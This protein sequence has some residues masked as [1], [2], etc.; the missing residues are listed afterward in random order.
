MRF[1]VAVHRVAV[2][3]LGERFALLIFQSRRIG[4]LGAAVSEYEGKKLF[5]ELFPP[6]LFLACQRPE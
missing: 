5:K 4:K 6:T 2:K 3:D 1:L